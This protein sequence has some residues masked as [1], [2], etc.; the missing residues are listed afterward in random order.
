MVGFNCRG[1]IK[2]WGPS[3]QALGSRILSYPVSTHVS[4]PVNHASSHTPNTN[5]RLTHLEYG[6]QEWPT[7]TTMRWLDG[8]R[9]AW[10]HASSSAAAAS[11][12]SVGL[13]CRMMGLGLYVRWWAL[14][15]LDEKGERGSREWIE[16]D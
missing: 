10:A 2:Y 5:Q 1:Q 15:V 14:W 3:Q 6:R 16:I 12:S 9:K 8:T 7:G 4:N 11:R 13:Q